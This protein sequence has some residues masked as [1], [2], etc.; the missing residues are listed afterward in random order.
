MAWSVGG[1]DARASARVG[2]AIQLWQVVSVYALM[3]RM[4]ASAGHNVVSIWPRSHSG[5]RYAGGELGATCFF[6]PQAEIPK[7]LRA[8]MGQGEAVHFGSDPPRVD[9]SWVVT[10][11][12]EMA[13]TT[14]GDI[15]KG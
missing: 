12:D 11:M 9:G 1:V 3:G 14:V 8:L 6:D 10:M 15:V 13:P 5:V 7:M 4:G 2:D